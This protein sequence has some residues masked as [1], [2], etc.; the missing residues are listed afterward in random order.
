MCCDTLILACSIFNFFLPSAMDLNT[1]EKYLD[2]SP[3]LQAHK[4][5]FLDL[6]QPAV[7]IRLGKGQGQPLQSRF[8]GQPMVPPGFTWPEHPDGEYLFVG[9][10]NFAELPEG[11]DRPANLPTSGLLSLFYG[12]DQEDVIFWRDEDYLKAF[13]WPDT[14]DF[15]ELQA[16]HD[17]GT[18]SREVL[19]ENCID[20][21]RHE[22]LRK[23]WP[24]DMDELYDWFEELEESGDLPRDYL[25]G[26]PSWDSLGYDPTPTQDEYP[27][28][29]PWRSLLTL[30]S[31]D[32]LN[33]CWQ[34]GA[35]L[36]AFIE[37]DKLRAKD[38]SRLQVDCG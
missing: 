4:Q 15:H 25:L 26:R 9:Q 8:G 17:W 30:Q 27:S 3:V 18:A 33:W 32:E 23:D 13:Y 16:P 38:F 14:T 10:I 24:V 12:M 22:E 6:A 36:M 5:Y 20:I 34:D 7:A 19:F 29:S 1:L 2:A 35:R 37:E 28:Q 31:H 11:P 21:P